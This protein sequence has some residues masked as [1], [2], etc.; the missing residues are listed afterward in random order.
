[1]K[2]ITNIRIRRE[3]ERKFERDV[4]ERCGEESKLIYKYTNRK[5][6]NQETITKL[7]K[8]NRL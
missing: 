7:I 3:K 5:M 2:Q 6:T 8:R 4:V 1:M